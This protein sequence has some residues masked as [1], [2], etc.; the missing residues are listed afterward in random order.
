MGAK[1]VAYY[2]QAFRIA[3]FPGKVE[4]ARLTRIPSAQA[5]ETPDTPQMTRA[6][7]EAMSQIRATGAAN[8]AGSGAMDKVMSRVKY[9]V[10]HEKLPLAAAARRVTEAVA[11]A[12]KVERSSVWAYDSRKRTIKCVDLYSQKDRGH[13][14]G[15]ELVAK[16][17]P[18]YFDA[19]ETEKTIAAN[20]A[21]RDYRTSE[22]SAVYLKP[23]GINSMIDVPIWVRGQMYGVLCNEHT[24][25]ARKWTAEEEDFAYSAGSLVSLVASSSPTR[26]TG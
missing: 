1:L 3:G 14:S 13:S 5:E 21:H 6:F 7:E 10:L 16:D 4:L 20:D 19:L 8:V 18:K 17:F 15:T 9:Q 25:A 24:G 26:A 22:F 12:L 23:L 2:S 11:E